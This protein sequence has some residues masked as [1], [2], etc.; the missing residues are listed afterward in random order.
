MYDE[1]FSL[2]L[3]KL[4]IVYAVSSSQTTKKEFE[5][6]NL[7]TS[8]GTDLSGSFLLASYWNIFQENVNLN[9]CIFENIYLLTC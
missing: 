1:I 2:I 5:E 7:V 3:V 4:D 6:T 8:N 9:L